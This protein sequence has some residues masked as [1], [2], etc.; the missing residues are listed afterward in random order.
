MSTHTLGM[1]GRM[2]SQWIDLGRSVR[3]AGGMVSQDKEENNV[4]NIVKGE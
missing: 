1:F 3:G 4:G 2:S